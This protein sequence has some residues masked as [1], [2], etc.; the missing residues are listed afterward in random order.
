[1]RRDS[2]KINKFYV[3]S[4]GKSAKLRKT[5]KCENDEELDNVLYKWSIQK[6]SA[7][8]PGRYRKQLLSKLLYEGDDDEEETACSIVQFW[9]ALPLKDCVYMINEA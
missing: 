9:K 4:N 7:D 2:K 5:I 8:G 1:M 3:A 6:R